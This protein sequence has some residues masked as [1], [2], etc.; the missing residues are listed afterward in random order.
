MNFSEVCNN[1]IIPNV[2]GPFEV[3]CVIL[4]SI[5]RIEKD[6]SK[7][8]MNEKIYQ[9]FASLGHWNTSVLV[10]LALHLLPV[11]GAALSLQCRFLFQNICYLT[12][13]FKI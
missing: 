10:I 13:T 2:V 11:W 1:L 4:H 3:R 12:N 7:N 8:Y 5:S 6:H 9:V